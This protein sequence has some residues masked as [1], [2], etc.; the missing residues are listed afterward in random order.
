[1]VKVV[2]KFISHNGY[3]IVMQW[4][5]LKVC[6]GKRTSLIMSNLLNQSTLV[7]ICCPKC[8]VEVESCYRSLLP[9]ITSS[10]LPSPNCSRGRHQRRVVKRRFPPPM[11]DDGKSENSFITAHMVTKDGE[12]IITEKKMEKCKA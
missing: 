12:G 5:T 1:M 3:P 6:F 8:S 2:D 4:L 10:S 9:Y 11:A 7:K